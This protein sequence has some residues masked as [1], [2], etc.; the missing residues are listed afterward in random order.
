[1]VNGLA[2]RMLGRDS[3]VDDLVQD[4]FVEAL[5]N[6]HRLENPGAFGSWIGSIVV[7]TAS[8][9]LRTRSM[10]TRLGLRRPMP[11]DADSV[12]SPRAPPEAAMELR[13]VYTVLA[14]LHHEARIALVLHRVEGMSMPEVADAMGV[15]LS[16][17]KR[18][19]AT[20]DEALSKMGPA[21]ENLP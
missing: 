10:L 12:I 4:T 17:A 3:E 7:R 11:I 6:L 19:L 8:K 16:T 1:M 14:P 21:K 2:Y 5:K 15:S 13:A 18:R 20:A 9:R